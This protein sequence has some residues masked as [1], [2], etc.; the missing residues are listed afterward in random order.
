[1]TKKKT[2]VKDTTLD[3]SHTEQSAY[4]RDV[5]NHGGKEDVLANPDSLPET[6]CPTPSTPHLIYGEAVEHL[7]GRQKEVYFLVMRENKSLAEASEILGIEKGTAQKYKDRAIKFIE[8][9]CKQAIA[10]GRI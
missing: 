1:M 6:F 10:K 3:S 4:W 8:N 7:Q 9:W 5:D 2:K